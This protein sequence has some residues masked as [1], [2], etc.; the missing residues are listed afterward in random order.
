MSSP[1]GGAGRP[2]RLPWLLLLFVG[3]GGAA[4]IY[5][6]VWLQLLQLVIGLT[7]VSLGLLLAVFMG[8]MC[9]GSVLLPRWVA[10]RHHPLR[11]YAWL[12]LGI[13]LIGIG[14]LFAVPWLGR[15]Y[16]QVG[17][18]GL[19]GLI[20]RGALVTLCLLPPTVLMGATLP[21]I[22]RSV[23][24]TPEG[25]AWLGFFYGGN[26]AGAVLGCLAAGF[27]LLRVYDMATATYV[28]AAI[29]LLVA[30]VAWVL[31]R[32]ESAPTEMTAAAEEPGAPV[33]RAVRAG[34]VYLA[35]GLSG[36]SALGA[37]VVWTRLLSL[38]FG[39][40]VYTFSIILA[41]FLAGLGMGSS[42]GAAL[43][44][45]LKRPEA[46]LGTCQAL[47]MGAIAWNAL[48]IARW[49]PYW[50]VDP[51]LATGPWPVFQM[52]LARSLWVTLPAAVLWG[53]SFP[54]ALAALATPGR[55]P[56][57]LVGGVY[58]ANTVGA[59]L[60]ALVFSIAVI[61]QWGTQGGQRLLI[62]VV[63]LAAL[64]MAWSWP[65][66]VR[67]RAAGLT[68][69]A[70]I[71]LALVWS[72]PE[73][74]WGLG[75][76]GR[77]LPSF[78][79]RLAPT[80]VEEQRLPAATGT[81]RPDIFP[82]YVGEGING[83]VA[84]SQWASGVRNF[85]SAGKV[86]NSTDPRDMRITRMLGHLPA[87][88]HPKPESVLVIACG[89]GVTAGTFV[90]H[91]E[92]RRIVICELE[93]LVPRHVAPMFARENHAVLEDPRTR[94]IID[95]GRHFINTTRERFDIITSDPLDPYV[96][97]CAALNTV[98]F[99]TRCKERLNPGGVITHWIPLY[100]SNL[101]TVKSG[102]A[103]FFQVF[104][105]G[106]LWHNDNRRGGYDAVLFGQAGPTRIEVDQLQ[107]RLDRP[108]HARVRQSLAE[109]GFQS[110]VHLLA[111]YAGR[112]ADLRDWM[113][114]AQ[115]NADRNLRLQYLAG[116]ALNAVEGPQILADIDRHRR[117][118]EELFSGSE[119]SKLALKIA[120][121]L[122]SLRQR[123]GM[124]PE[125]APAPA[126][127]PPER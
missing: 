79:R 33:A 84:V 92:I 45:R 102:I 124:L 26:I 11:V 76:Y 87:L 73:T 63:A 53:A 112:A 113:S 59:I 55:D 69:L 14:V 89:A 108:D 57:R 50:P 39:G 98:E 9:L 82:L 18:P 121:N 17:G 51:T 116:L 24:A 32:G 62:V 30:A 88:L 71:A 91:P 41:A 111:T 109:V 38:L 94:V 43:A 46:A 90:V 126:P 47:L 1:A 37:E 12:E 123:S 95:D 58:A 75:A 23:R 6:V 48:S 65:A 27:Y 97:G 7:T 35:I 119:Q 80:V 5:Q 21:A 16:Q 83:S 2:R 81:G 110:A 120:I 99:F 122:R 100:E 40:T 105:D 103:S 22:S 10:P 127:S 68:A 93:P 13:G 60:G 52:D 36:L 25:V 4:L 49:L 78:A 106:I 20:A 29:N 66:P 61:P 19:P 56:G 72:V 8:G 104:P 64:V 85:H 31:A 34:P 54:L 67:L 70:G 28:A 115:L 77:F 117:F 42:T 114:G 3:S 96:K 86:Q 74:P 101:E 107:A 15:W 125:R 118:P 44:R